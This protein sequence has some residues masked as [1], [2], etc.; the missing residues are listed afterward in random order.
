MKEM[1]FNM[2]KGDR[3]LALD[4]NEIYI[5]EH[6]VKADDSEYEFMEFYKCYIKEDIDC[7]DEKKVHVCN[8]DTFFLTRSECQRHI[9]ANHYHYLEPHTYA[10]TLFRCPT[11]S[12]IIKIIEETD[13]DKVEVKE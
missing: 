7:F 1:L 10:R 8:N 9:D 11:M 5:L 3:I 2:S 4:E 13:W 12:K 6:D